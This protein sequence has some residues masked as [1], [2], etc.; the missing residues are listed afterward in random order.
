MVAQTTIAF[1]VFSTLTFAGCSSAV[2]LKDFDRGFDAPGLNILP[3]ARQADGPDKADFKLRD[4]RTDRIRIALNRRTESKTVPALLVDTAY[5]K[6]IRQLS[7]GDVSLF[8]QPAGTNL[9]PVDEE[10][11]RNYLKTNR[12][13]GVADLSLIEKDAK[14]FSI[15]LELRDPYDGELIT[16]LT[17]DFQ[18]RERAVDPAHQLDFYSRGGT[19]VF[20]ET[21]QSPQVVMVQPR[22]REA[23]YEILSQTVTGKVNVASS[24][25][26]TEVYLWPAGNQRK[27]QKLGN[28]PIASRRLSEGKHTLEIRR[29]GFQTQ[30][31]PIQVRSGKNLDVIAPWPDDPAIQTATILSAPPGMQLSMDGT[32]RGETPVYLTG[33]ESGSYNLEL[34][35]GTKAGEFEVIAEGQMEVAESDQP[36]RLFLIDYREDF[37]TDVTQGDLWRLSS[38]TGKVVQEPGENGL[39]FKNVSG[40][41]DSWQGLVSQPFYADNFQMTARVVES[42]NGVIAFGVR[43]G[44]ST[45]LVEVNNNVYTTAIYGP[46][47]K[48]EFAS[49]QARVKSPDNSHFLRYKFKR[50]T[51]ELQI[52]L[53]G[54]TIFKGPF[55]AA[56]T[57]RVL[58]LTRASSAD[59]RVLAKSFSI[60]GGR[61]LL[62]SQVLDL[63][64][65]NE[66]VDWVRSKWNKR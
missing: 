20:L 4:A 60:K 1:L 28:T 9:L 37:S 3:V 50:E 36:Q 34:A 21:R 44:D 12:I 53:D 62:D 45:V 55:A 56:P 49:Y 14:N 22:P 30:I 24:T 25:T 18:V 26:E 2:P 39:A 17:Q 58:L 47:G 16:D 35:R 29:R 64:F 33:L 66:F 13:D 32:V 31:R 43:S 51:G 5:Q 15:K 23:L 59:G 42:E 41:N 46:E 7:F 65:V 6:F 48:K 8:S 10:A 52:K 27:R 57:G 61:G 54:T 11:N 19:F 40:E 63:P 38:E